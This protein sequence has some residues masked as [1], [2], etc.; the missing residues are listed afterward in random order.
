MSRKELAR[1]IADAKGDAALERNAGIAGETAEGLVAFARA[2]GYA[3]DLG[4]LP[5]EARGQRGNAIAGPGDRG[6]A[7]RWGFW[8]SRNAPRPLTT[9]RL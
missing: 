2:R 6:G 8:G 5:G 9:D 3:I 1:F 7:D 4:D